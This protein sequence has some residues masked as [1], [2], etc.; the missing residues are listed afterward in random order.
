[1]QPLLDLHLRVD[2]FAAARLALKL[3]GH[4]HEE[5]SS[6]LLWLQNRIEGGTPNQTFVNR[7][8]E[9][10]ERFPIQ[11]SPLQVNAA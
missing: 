3:T 4:E 1:M 11:V 8:L 2:N 5:Y 9:W 7:C 6:M 10:L